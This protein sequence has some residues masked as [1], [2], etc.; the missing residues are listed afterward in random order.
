VTRDGFAHRA[1]LSFSYP[2]QR[3]A[4]AVAD[5][6]TVERGEISEVARPGDDGDAG[7]SATAV[8]CEAETLTVEV[9]AADLVALR[10]GLN[11]WRRLVGVAE[12]VAAAAE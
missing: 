8:E 5:A 7:R 1:T 3:R 4:R 11:T 2:D 10:A 9:R 6:V 12:R